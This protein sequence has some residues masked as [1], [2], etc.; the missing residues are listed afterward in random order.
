M[1]RLKKKL[2]LITPFLCLLF[3]QISCSSNDEPAG[4][5]VEHPVP[6]LIPHNDR[7]HIPIKRDHSFDELADPSEAVT[8]LH[9]YLEN[10]EQ[11]ES[12]QLE[13]TVPDLQSL[14]VV[15]VGQDRLLFLDTDNDR[16]IEYD[17]SKGSSELI[18]EFG[19]GP[20][21]LQ[22]SIDLERVGD[23]VYVARRDMRLS[24][25]KC[26]SDSCTYDNTMILD[27]QPISI[28]SAEKGLAIT[29]GSIFS[30]G[31]EMVKDSTIDFPAVRIINT[32]DGK[33]SDSF[34][35]IYKT[36]F[37][38]VL[39]RF[40]RTGLIAYLPE[41]RRY[42]WASS[43][44][45]YLHIYNKDFELE[46]TYK[47]E[48]HIQNKFEFFPAEQR[49]R[50]PR[51]DRTLISQLKIIEEGR[52]L[53][54][55]TTRTNQEEEEEIVHNY[56]YDYYVIDFSSQKAIHLGTDRKTSGYQRMIFPFRNTLIKYDEGVLYRLFNE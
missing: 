24:R 4:R 44:F 33:P 30:G 28:S 53:L 38:M 41:H 1:F 18:A 20:G 32:N 7:D 29:T 48:H 36:Q 3:L 23:D 39:E 13:V 11:M 37:M 55:T 14:R 42:V 17:L 5:M 19:R 16:L 43:W 8:L 49:R 54:V 6:E 51:R 12:E 27:V 52:I 46:E 25:F 9:R 15:E 45:P 34:G 31:V 40:S 10:P 47:L 22:H 56:D 35:S 21:E 50:F 2:H 26:A